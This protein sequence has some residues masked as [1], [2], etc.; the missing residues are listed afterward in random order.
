MLDVKH[1]RY[2]QHNYTEGTE[3]EQ[4]ECAR[5]VN[6]A[7][8]GDGDVTPLLTRPLKCLLSSILRRKYDLLVGEKAHSPRMTTLSRITP[9]EYSLTTPSQ[10]RATHRRIQGKLALVRP[11]GE[12]IVVARF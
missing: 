7:Q 3:S 5:M 9:R 4:A 10:Q 1:N 11:D 12:H 2:I 8:N 6:E